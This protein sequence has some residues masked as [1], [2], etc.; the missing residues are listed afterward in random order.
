MCEKEAPRLGLKNEARQQRVGVREGAAA[1]ADIF[2]STTISSSTTTRFVCPCVRTSTFVGV[3][4]QAMSE[5]QK[6]NLSH[7]CCVLLE[8]TLWMLLYLPGA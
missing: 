4:E 8:F 3:F 6:E 1:C 7:F 2:L 5:R